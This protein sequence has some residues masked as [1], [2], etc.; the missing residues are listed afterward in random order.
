[1][2]IFNKYGLKRTKTREIIIEKLK[3]LNSPISSEELH[4]ILVED[5]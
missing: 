4:S 2:D 3:Q 1:M 5:F